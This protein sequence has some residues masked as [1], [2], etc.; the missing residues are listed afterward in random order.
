MDRIQYSTWRGCLAV[1]LLT[2]TTCPVFAAAAPST[3]DF[4]SLGYLP[5]SGAAYGTYDHSFS[6]VSGISADGAL[7]VGSSGAVYHFNLTGSGSDYY[8]SSA[9]AF[10]WSASTGIQHLEGDDGSHTSAGGISGDGSTVFGDD[11]RWTAAGGFTPLQGLLH[12]NAISYDGAVVV[13]SSDVE[14]NHGSAPQ[15][16]RWSQTSGAQALASLPGFEDQSAANGV[17]MDGSVVVGTSY[18][19]HYAGN[20]RL[21]QSQAFR[22]TQATGIVG[23]GYLPNTN[24]SEAIAVSGDGSVVAGNSTGGTTH[25][26]RWTAAAGMT[27]LGVLAGSYESFAKAI[28]LDGK[29]IVGTSTSSFSTGVKTLRAIRWTEATG[30]QTIEDWLATAGV[31]VPASMHLTTA[32]A[33]N[34]DGSV[35]VGN[36]NEDK[37]DN[38]SQGWLAR[39]SPTGSG[40]LTNLDGFNGSVAESQGRTMSG[41]TDLAQLALDGAHRRSLL[42]NDQVEGN[43]GSCAWATVDAAYFDESGTHAQLGEI[44]ACT[45]IGATRIGLGLGKEHASQDWELGGNAKLNGH[46]VL[47]EVATAFGGGFEGSLLG[48]RGQFDIDGRRDY[49]NGADVDTS[50]SD[51]DATSTAARARLDW[52]DAVH[53][54]RASIS[55]YAT[56]TWT[57]SKLDAYSERSGGFPVA[58][59]AATW[60]TREAR[61][62]AASSV[63]LSSSIGLRVAIEA[64]HRFEGHSATVNGQVVDLFTVAAPGQRLKAN[65]G[66]A[67]V[68]LD[69]RLSDA[70]YIGIGANG[71]TS[72]GDANWG[73]TAQYHMTF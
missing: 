25:L 11:F 66:R 58:F 70:S 13:G 73:L 53:A 64:V 33:T 6:T 50:T 23:L 36:T 3:G 57:N 62:G 71:A 17:S 35:V 27:D 34:R 40:L 24:E 39:V 2:S 44:G 41:V 49:F 28:S 59:G 32:T 56:Y 16:F 55:P 20:I 63:V 38:S 21:T 69:Y 45:D 18:N 52:K 54:G 46:Y 15:A 29:V 9:S 67:L 31:A 72:G 60:I 1:A 65:W 19:A 10:R 30:I 47:A 37:Y 12:A 48:Y 5:P 22:W 26:F 8:G 43:G 4:V 61:L 14:K 68:D 7:V 51:H 42:D